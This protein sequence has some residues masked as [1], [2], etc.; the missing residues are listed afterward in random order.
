MRISI[1]TTSGCSFATSKASA[2]DLTL[3]ISANRARIPS[4]GGWVPSYFT[5]TTFDKPAMQPSYT[6]EN[7]WS[8][9]CPDTLDRVHREIPR[10][11]NARHFSQ[12]QEQALQFQSD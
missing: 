6:K 3:R 1:R 8:R 2:L 10:Q 9:H 7:E 5:A 12:I 11:R 4:V